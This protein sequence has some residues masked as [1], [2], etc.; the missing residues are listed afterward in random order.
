VSGPAIPVHVFV[1]AMEG[2]KE[3]WFLVTTALDLTAAHVV[4]V[5]TA[6]FRHEDA[7]RDHKQR[8]GMEEC[9][10]WTKEPLLRTFQVQLVALTLLRL[11]QARLNQAWSPGTWWLKPEWNPHKRHG[12]ILDLRRLFWR[13]RTEFSQLLVDL[14]NLEKLPQLLAL[15]RDFRGRAA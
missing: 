13:H 14:E 8:L 10:A 7:F 12:S 2:Y 5:F 11:L 15:Q 1:V 4:E 9:R 3:P 6:R